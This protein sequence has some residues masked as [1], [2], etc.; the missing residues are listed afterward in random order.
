D[1]PFHHYPR[2]DGRG[3]IEASLRW[4]PPR[5]QDP[6][7]GLMAAAPLKLDDPVAGRAAERAIRGLMAAAPLKLGLARVP[8]PDRAGYP[9]PD[10]RGSIEARPTRGTRRSSCCLSAA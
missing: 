5:W 1:G 9:R 10:G 7:R 4:R 3:S 2:P 8:R 6:I